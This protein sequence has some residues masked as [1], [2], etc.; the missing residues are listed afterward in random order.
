MTSGFDLSNNHGMAIRVSRFVDRI[1]DRQKVFIGL[2]F[3]IIGVGYRAQMRGKDILNLYLGHSHPI[4][5]FLPKGVTATV[6]AGKGNPKI[7]LES[8]DKQLVG[9]VAA[10]IRRLREPEPYNGK[11]VRYVGEYVKKKV[12]KAVVGSG[13]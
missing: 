6:E 2:G 3:E 13:K 10:Q 7:K 9:E 1:P 5:Y 11:G 12:G 4:D 8:C